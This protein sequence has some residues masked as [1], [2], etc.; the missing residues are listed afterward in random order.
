MLA[1]HLL[2]DLS[3]VED[4]A[5]ASLI[6]AAVQGSEKAGAFLL[7]HVVAPIGYDQLELRALGQARGLVHDE[8]AVLHDSLHVPPV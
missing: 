1:A 8:P 6:D 5:R 7:V 2:D 3:G 4:L